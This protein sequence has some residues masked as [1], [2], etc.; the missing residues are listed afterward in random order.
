MASNLT[1]R[2]EQLKN[3]LEWLEGSLEELQEGI[4]TSIDDPDVYESIYN[5]KLE[6]LEHVTKEIINALPDE[7]KRKVVNLKLFLDNSYSY[8][9][10][11]TLITI[12]EGY[13]TELELIQDGKQSSSLGVLLKA[14]NMNPYFEQ[15]LA[16]MIC[17]YPRENSRETN[18]PRRDWEKIKRLFQIAGIRLEY[19]EPDDDLQLITNELKRLNIRQIHR[20]VS[21]GLFNK[22]DFREAFDTPSS[23]WHW[24]E[25]RAR[26]QQEFKNF[27]ENSL[28]DYQEMNLS[29]LLGQVFDLVLSKSIKTK[30]EELNAL[31]AEAKEKYLIK[32][33][34]QTAI[35]KL[36]D[37]FERIKTYF[38]KNK[39]KSSQKL[40]DI[41]GVSLDKECMEKE[42]KKLRHVG[43]K[44]RIRHHETDK[45]KIEDEAVMDYLFIRML[46][47]LTF[48][49]SKINEQENLS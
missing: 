19:Y 42:F 41:I 31:I 37:A 4:R 48:L 12:I 27:I 17:G 40:L 18:F 29:S 36:W 44:T 25:W 20:L 3:L 30:D 7:Y 1:E 49:A 14:R 39:R 8:V 6:T 10:F 24:E 22:R 13:I 9:A 32:S 26:A 34:R 33:E 38:D 47:L 15:D 35:E 46:N 21:Q 11:K 5:S 43:N 28:T 2:I 45:T 16:K 23:P